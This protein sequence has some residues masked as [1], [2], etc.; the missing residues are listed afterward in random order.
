MHCACRIVG[1]HVILCLMK[2]ILLIDDRQLGNIS[3]ALHVCLKD[4][5]GKF[6]YTIWKVVQVHEFLISHRR[7]H[8]LIF[9]STL[10]VRGVV[11]TCQNLRNRNTVMLTTLLCMNCMLCGFVPVLLW[12]NFIP[13][14]LT[15]PLTGGA[16][17]VQK[18]PVEMLLAL[19]P[20][21]Y[22]RGTTIPQCKHT[23]STCWEVLRTKAAAN[24]QMIWLGGTVPLCT[25]I[26]ISIWST[27]LA[28]CALSFFRSPVDIFMHYDAK[29]MEFT[30]S[31]PEKPK[32]PKNSVSILLKT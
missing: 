10:N 19:I 31:I 6:M 2:L 1:A 17:F 21:D 18:P 8:G 22:C 5:I 28:Y 24:F 26:A 13:S 7:S 11:C 27:L 30:P 3:N 14:L 23:V 20:Y 29:E 9:S 32:F 16:S 15:K 4:Q 12:W 25:I